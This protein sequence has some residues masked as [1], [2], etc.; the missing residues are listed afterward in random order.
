[1]VMS[2]STHFHADRTA[3]IDYYK[4][5]GIKTYTTKQTDELSKRKGEPRAEYLIFK[6]TSFHIGQYS[7]STFYPGKG[8]SPD[9]IVIWFGKEKVLY[10]G[11]FIKSTETNNIGNLSDASV[12]E[13][14]IS[15]QKVIAKF[16]NPA[17]VIPGHQGWLS[18]TAVSHTI[19]VVKDYKKNAATNK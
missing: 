13:W 5:K 18:N 16:K 3:G 8:H 6:D 10:G 12:D 11:C 9:N 4:Q 2:I 15:L 17:F 7:F 14:V 19:Q 1:V